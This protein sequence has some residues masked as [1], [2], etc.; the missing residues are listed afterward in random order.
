MLAKGRGRWAVSQKRM[1]IPKDT[2]PPLYKQQ[3]IL[4][5]LVF[6]KTSGIVTGDGPVSYWSMFSLSLVTGSQW[7]GGFD[8]WTVI[9]S[10]FDG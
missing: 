8:G 1:M 9:F 10:N 5:E 3:G 4:A 2:N 6:A 7:G